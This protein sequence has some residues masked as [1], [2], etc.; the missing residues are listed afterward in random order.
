MIALS[1]DSLLWQKKLIGS[2]DILYIATDGK[3]NHIQWLPP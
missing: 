1:R 2:Y 3:T